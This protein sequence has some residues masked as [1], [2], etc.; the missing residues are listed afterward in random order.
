MSHL[1]QAII[2]PLNDEQTWIETSNFG[3]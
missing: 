1:A 2:Q 3:V